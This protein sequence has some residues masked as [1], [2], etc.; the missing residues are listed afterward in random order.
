MHQL[1]K[2]QELSIWKQN[3]NRLKL[4]Q[5]AFEVAYGAQPIFR[6]RGQIWLPT[7]YV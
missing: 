2:E 7:L 5:V 6:I 4:Q 1:K 3:K